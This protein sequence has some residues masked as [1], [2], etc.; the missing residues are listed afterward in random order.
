MS[1]DDN[2][3][4]P[5]QSGNTAANS[6]SAA[7]GKDE[8]RRWDFAPNSCRC[9][10]PGAPT[11][12]RT[13]PKGPAPVW[14]AAAA[15]GWWLSLGLIYILKNTVLK[16]IGNLGWV[17]KSSK[18]N[19]ALWKGAACPAGARHSSWCIMHFLE[20]PSLPT[21]NFANFTFPWVFFSTDFKNQHAGMHI[22]I[23]VHLYFQ[24]PPL[25]SLP[26]QCINVTI[27]Y[28]LQYLEDQTLKLKSFKTLLLMQPHFDSLQMQNNSQI[29]K[30]EVELGLKVS[31][32]IMGCGSIGCDSPGWHRQ[33]HMPSL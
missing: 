26:R 7:Q 15:R 23:H 9:V 5:F 10:L 33:N 20:L 19:P 32:H 1:G 27:S 25:L 3:R 8:G 4:A 11:V 6:I 12:G 14:W 29:G 21:T 13:P 30:W 16:I 17:I 18:V 22:H 31:I 2:R 28:Y 24:I